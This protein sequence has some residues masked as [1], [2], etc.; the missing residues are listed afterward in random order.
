MQVE[1][2]RSAMRLPVIKVAD[3]RGAERW[4]LNQAENPL[5]L[6][7][8]V[9]GYTQALTSITTDRRNTLRW[10]KGKKLENLPH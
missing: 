2:N 9:R 3:D 5:L 8:S 6:K 1:V 4:F 7:L 10:I